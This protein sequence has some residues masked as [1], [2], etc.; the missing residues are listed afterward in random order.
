MRIITRLMGIAY[1]LRRANAWL[2]EEMN[3]VRRSGFMVEMG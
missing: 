2:R 1:G 3:D